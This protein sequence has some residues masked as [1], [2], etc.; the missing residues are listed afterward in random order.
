MQVTNSTPESAARSVGTGTVTL[1]NG[2][3]QADGPTNLTFS[4][5]FKV[6]NFALG[7]GIDSN[8]ATLTISGNITDGSGGRES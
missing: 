1:E 5:T 6:N 4:N 7:S 8:D 3:F 2:Q